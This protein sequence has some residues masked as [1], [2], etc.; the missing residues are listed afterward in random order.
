MP[1]P[2]KQSPQPE[3]LA[4]PPVPKLRK[5]R[6]DAKPI[7]KK[8][9]AV[10]Q[11]EFV[12]DAAGLM[13]GVDEAGRGPLAGNVVAAAV[14]LDDANP[15]AG[16][17]DSKKLTAL[18]RE[19]L[20]IEIQAKALCVSIGEASVEEI[21]QLNILQATML[22]MQ[23]AVNGL[24]LKPAKVLIDGNRI[25]KL[26][27]LAEAIV[28]GDAKVKAISAAS[29]IA[30]VT[31]DRQCDELHALYPQYGFANH[32]GYGTAEHLAA[33]KKHGATP[34]HRKSYAPVAQAIHQSAA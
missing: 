12:W 25:P 4:L 31:R 24:R 21:D 9:L 33:L 23:R 32:K 14:I 7:R 11:T 10:V 18:R 29:I 28:G 8:K 6:S 15:I 5:R 22:A 13:A 30:K 27:V 1:R 3:L 26:D 34:E 20:F 16:L 19:K 17:N 2:L